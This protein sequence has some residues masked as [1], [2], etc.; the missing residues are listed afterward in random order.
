MRYW[1]LIGLFLLVGLRNAFGEL[2]DGLILH[3]PCDEGQGTVLRDRSPT[4]ASV[5]LLGNAQ[6]TSGPGGFGRALDFRTDVESVLKVTH[7]FGTLNRMSV[8]FHFYAQDP[9]P[10]RWGYFLD[11]R[12]EEILEDA[13]AFYIARNREQVIRLVNDEAASDTYPRGRW[14]HLTILADKQ[15]VSFYVDGQKVAEGNVVPLNIGNRLL[16]GNRYT[17]NASFTGILD[18]IALWNRLL[19]KTEITQLRDRPIPSPQPVEPRSRL[20][21]LWAALKHVQERP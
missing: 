1:I 19:D 13:G 17:K 4:Q 5:A 9:D 18:D 7:D 2:L 16:I 20:P 12:T 15:G 14:S 21:I 11:T 6:W 10:P 8:S 3:L